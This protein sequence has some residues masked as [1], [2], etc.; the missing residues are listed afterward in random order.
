M[1]KPRIPLVTILLILED[2][3]TCSA[4]DL[5]DSIKGFG[6]L[7]SLSGVEVPSFNP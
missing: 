6:V 3:N 1:F 7:R 4:V 5:M 2:E